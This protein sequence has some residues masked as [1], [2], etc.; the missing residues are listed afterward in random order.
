V[1]IEKRNKTLEEFLNDL[2]LSNIGKDLCFSDLDDDEDDN[3]ILN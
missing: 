3:P 2:D 1:K